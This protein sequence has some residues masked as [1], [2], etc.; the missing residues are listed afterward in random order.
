MRTSPLIAVTLAVLTACATEV[1]APTASVVASLSV[2]TGAVAQLDGSASSDPAGRTLTYDWSFTAVPPG[3]TAALNDPSIAKPSFT[4]DVAGTYDVQLVVSNGVHPSP[5][6]KVTVTAT[7]VRPIASAIALVADVP[8]GALVQLNGQGSSDPSGLPLSFAWSFTAKPPA[9]LAALNDPALAMPAFRA[10]VP[11]VYVAQ[12]VVSNGVHQSLP[13][14]VTV[15]ASTCGTVRP[16]AQVQLLAPEAAGPAAQVGA[17]RIPVGAVVS[18]SG[19]ASSDPD[20]LA[21]CSAGQTLSYRWTLDAIPAGSGATLNSATAVNPTFTAGVPGTYVL[22][23]V[24]TD[25]A[26]LSSTEATLT[27]TADPS[28]GSVLPIAGFAIQ[29][30]NAGTAQAMNA[31]RGLAVDGAGV[32]YVAQSGNPRRVTRHQAGSVSILAESAY[33]GSALGDIALDT[34]AALPRLLVTSGARIVAVDPTSGLQS[35]FAD[36]SF[37]GGGQTFQGITVGVTATTA[38][39]STLQVAA[40]D[41]NNDQILLFDPATAAAAGTVPFGPGTVVSPWGVA[42][43]SPAAGTAGGS[44][45]WFTT[46]HG[47]WPNGS[48]EKLAGG[49]TSAL[50]SGTASG[51]LDL[52]RARDLALSPCPTPRLF[53]ANGSGVLVVDTVSG[54][55]ETLVTG[56][57][58]PAGLA[59][60]TSTSPPAL[61]L[62]DDSAK[63]AL[64]RI[65]GPFCTL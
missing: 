43:L 2:N 48:I 1:K 53:V 45:T 59:F 38:T 5:P 4:P 28:F 46:S 13:V 61:L 35:L 14:A 40:V 19:A 57:G 41:D 47:T 30:V 26:G 34:T 17:V 49:V 65:D 22:G 62:T 6:A 50:L 54:A 16:N 7:L 3:S 39:T 25:S 8:A 56:L 27:V 10:D 15:T 51:S 44:A 23:L 31:P 42:L 55:Y 18:A 32:V 37:G 64:Y 24:V 52:R 36:F 20:N 11:G 58:T 63:N 33:L 29:T 60:D 9:S 21:P 12:L